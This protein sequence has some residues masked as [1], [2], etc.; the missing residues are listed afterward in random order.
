MRPIE[1]SATGNLE[2]APCHGC[3]G[4][5]WVEVGDVIPGFALTPCPAT[6]PWPPSYRLY[7]YPPL[8][9]YTTF[10]MDCSTGGAHTDQGD[11]GNK[12]G[13]LI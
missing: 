13:T 5:G 7:S 6:Y 11:G 3:N 10:V 1:G 8:S 12:S 4:K 9:G 2:S